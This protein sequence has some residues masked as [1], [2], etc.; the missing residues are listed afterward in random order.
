MEEAPDTR[1]R[2]LEAAEELFSAHG[3]EGTSLRAITQKAGV[4]LALVNYHFGSK[5]QLLREIVSRRMDPINAERIRRLEDLE[6]RF[7]EAP[8][9]VE[10]ILRAL[11]E[12]FYASMRRDGPMAAGFMRLVNLPMKTDASFWQRTWQA[13]FRDLVRRST[14]LLQRSLPELP[15]EV[16]YWRLHLMVGAMISHFSTPAR[17]TLISEGTCDPD[18]Y[19]VAVNQLVSF[20]AAGFH[21]PAP[22]AV[23]VQ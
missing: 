5:T 10:E 14:R 19:E 15:E 6:E 7:G 18:D 2:L 13:H 12:P 23:S 11:I 21:A 3:F 16:L 4:G 1:H 17:L 9:P 22:S 20:L 8:P